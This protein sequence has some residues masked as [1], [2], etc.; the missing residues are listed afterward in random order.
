M[1]IWF[2]QMVASA[3][4]ACKRMSGNQSRTNWG[5]SG[6]AITADLER[7]R[8]VRALERVAAGE[9][10]AL[11]D[12]YRRTSA[13]L[14]GVVLRILGDR[15]EAEDV[16]QEV[17]ITVWNRAGSF[18]P[19]RGVSPITWL[20]AVARNRAIDRM[21]ARGARPTQPIEAAAD[22]ADPAAPAWAGLEAGDDTRRLNDCLK[23]LDE[24]QSHAIR[25]AFFDGVTYEVLAARLGAPL[26][27]VKSWIRR[28]LANLRGCL[29]A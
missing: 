8:L 28:G 10:A 25:T 19:A 29:E 5:L 1:K 17:Y 22:V 18:D 9:A 16:L 27:T 26:G 6:V 3:I 11:E 23:G 2:F 7:V 15:S 12:I 21:R 4:C 20:A 13:K 24:K 14:F